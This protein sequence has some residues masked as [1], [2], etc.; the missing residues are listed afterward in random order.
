V[1]LV[2]VY[3]KIDN[4]G[5]CILEAVFKNM[6]DFE[7]VPAHAITRECRINEETLEVFLKRLS[8]LKIL[9]NKY[10]EYLGTSFTFKGLSVYSLKK[11]VLKGLV[12]MLGNI[13][14]EGKE[15]VVYTAIAKGEEVVLKFHK[16][17]Y[18]SFKKVKEKRDLGTL[19]S[20]VLMVRS[21]KREYKAL[22]K[23][24]GKVSVPK[25]IS[26]EGNAVLMELIDAKELYKVKLKNPEDV[27]EMIIEET[28]EMY[29]AGI[30]HGDLSQY[31]ILVNEDGIYF[32][33]FPQYV[34]INHEMAEEL[35]ERDVSNIV[36]YFKRAYGIERDI[37]NL[38]KYVKS[39]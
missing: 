7:F 30:I 3:S 14:G 6:W 4:K 21:A 37:N 27:F 34:E 35:L 11:L 29:H 32:I 10:S 13:M 31:N 36:T 19:H 20:T 9:E 16:T 18:S 38:I 8:S 1:E 25:P 33:D 17:G 28:K 12:E 39:R 23:L 15:S 26:W 22:K 5:W 24:F 2:E